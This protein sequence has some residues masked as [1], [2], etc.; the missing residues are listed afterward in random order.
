MWGRPPRP[1]PLLFPDVPLTS[2][3]YNPGD[4]HRSL[5][6]DVQDPSP[7]TLKHSQNSFARGRRRPS[8]GAALSPV[9]LTASTPSSSINWPSQCPPPCSFKASPADYSGRNRFVQAG[10]PSYW[11]SP[12]SSSS[13]SAQPPST[14]QRLFSFQRS[15]VTL[16]LRAGVRNRLVLLHATCGD[17]PLR[18]TE[19]RGSDVLDRTRGSVALPRFPCRPPHSP[20]GRRSVRLPRQRLPVRKQRIASAL[21]MIRNLR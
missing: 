17:P 9:C 4:L 20:D 15:Y 19:T 10:L 6:S 21:S 2:E 12:F 13:R 7:C 8:S 5:P 3:R 11:A 16:D 14:T 1:S 18:R